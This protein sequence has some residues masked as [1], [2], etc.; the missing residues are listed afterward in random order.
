MRSMPPFPSGVHV[1][2]ASSPPTVSKIAKA[3][4]EIEARTTLT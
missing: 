4:K 1:G 3:I 2:G